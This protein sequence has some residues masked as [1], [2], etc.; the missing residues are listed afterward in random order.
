MR[1]PSSRPTGRPKGLPKTGG[2]S[3]KGRPN[4]MTS[5]IKAMCLAALRLEG[6]VDYIRR[7]ARENPTAFMGLLARILPTQ[8][9]ASLAVDVNVSLEA[10]RVIALELLERS[11]RRIDA[12]QDQTNEAEALPPQ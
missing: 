1:N 11:F 4:K 10:R 12:R 8:V 9:E 5:D 7:Q 2:G 3:R 6:G